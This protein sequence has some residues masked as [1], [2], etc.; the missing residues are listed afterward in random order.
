MVR[1]G[2]FDMVE[3]G[4]FFVSLGDENKMMGSGLRKGVSRE[5]DE[6]SKRGSK[7]K[8]RN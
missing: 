6:K 2:K 3:I 5:E 1:V 7:C 4:I 8:Q